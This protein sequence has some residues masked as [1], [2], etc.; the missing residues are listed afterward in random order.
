MPLIHA[1]AEI[2]S[3][4]RNLFHHGGARGSLVPLP[5]PTKARGIKSNDG[6]V[7]VSSDQSLGL[8]SST[9]IVEPYQELNQQTGDAVE[10]TRLDEKYSSTPTS[11]GIRRERTVQSEDGGRGL[12]TGDLEAQTDATEIHRGGYKPTTP[13]VNDT[14]QPPTEADLNLGATKTMQATIVILNQPET[15][16]RVPRRVKAY[17]NLPKFPADLGRSTS[18][19]IARPFNEHDFP[20][21]FPPHSSSVLRAHVSAPDT[22]RPVNAGKEDEGRVVQGDSNDQGVGHNIIITAPLP[23]LEDEG[24]LAVDA[25]LPILEDEGPLAVDVPDSSSSS[26]RDEETERHH[27]AGA[28]NETGPGPMTSFFSDSSGDKPVKGL[29]KRLSDFRI[30]LAQSRGQIT[31]PLTSMSVRRAGDDVDSAVPEVT[32]TLALDS[33]GPMGPTAKS[34]PSSAAETSS[35]GKTRGIRRK[36]SMW[37]KTAGHAITARRSQQLAHTTSGGE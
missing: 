27:I 25:P 6:P 15:K 4:G 19:A 8:P 9:P 36:V 11:P 12:G 16:H 23:I 21:R 10:S 3:L 2:G 35:L 5:L 37:L 28:S 24:P 14:K 17:S 18:A 33:T 29:K 13:T 32:A 26:H 20:I 31:R 34:R 30:R 1:Q 22:L 7:N